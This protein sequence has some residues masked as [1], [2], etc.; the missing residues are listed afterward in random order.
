MVN[1]FYG[2]E[3]KAKKNEINKLRKESGMKGDYELG[4]LDSWQGKASY[5]RHTPVLNTN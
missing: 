3:R 5:Y 4:L 2:H 1:H